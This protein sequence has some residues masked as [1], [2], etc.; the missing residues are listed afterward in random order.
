MDRICIGVDENGLGA[1]LGPLVV[2]AVG[3]RVAAGSKIGRNTETLARHARLLDDSKRLVSHKD[4][5]LGEAWA[6]AILG[7]DVSRPA[8]LLEA[9]GLDSVAESMSIC[10]THV[11]AQCWAE[12]GEEFS[13]PDELVHEVGDCLGSLRKQGLTLC[14]VRSTWI[15]TRML[16]RHLANGHHRFLVDLHSMERLLLNMREQLGVKL[17][18]ICGKVGGIA[19]YP[20]YFGPLGGRLYTVVEQERHRSCYEFAQLG[21]ISFEQDADSH[22]ALVMIASLIGKYVR[23][24]FMARIARHYDEDD[25]QGARPSGY[26]DPVTQKFVEATCNLRK[27][28]RVPF[29]CFERKRADH[30]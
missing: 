13:A 30:E 20:R 5:R 4:V 10:P 23:E 22:D 26:H 6:R 12:S 14:I 9:I 29:D 11:K 8:A 19:D 28:R 17:D 18:A 2:T 7:A 21:R 3:A 16:N 15:C 25:D 1:Q 27:S 24:L